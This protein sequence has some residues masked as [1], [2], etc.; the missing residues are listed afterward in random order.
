M[1]QSGSFPSIQ[2]AIYGGNFNS[3]KNI[4]FGFFS[5][6][7]ETL[8][9]HNGK[10]SASFSFIK[11]RN[12]SPCTWTGSLTGQGQSLYMSAPRRIPCN[13]RQFIPNILTRDDKGVPKDID[14]ISER[15][16]LQY[17]IPQTGTPIVVNNFPFG[18][19]LICGQFK[20]CY[21]GCDPKGC[22]QNQC[23]R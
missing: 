11:N 21:A 6:L 20:K 7:I 8:F 1:I 15:S 23:C 18:T 16:Q 19:A 5:K 14:P 13:N 4:L 22:S 12:S 2:S 3:L 17:F 9:L 10:I